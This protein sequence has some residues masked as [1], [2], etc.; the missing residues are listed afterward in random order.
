MSTP[1]TQTNTL[2]QL[3]WGIILGTLLT[4]GTIAYTL[5]KIKTTTSFGF[6]FDDSWIHAVFVRNIVEHGTF[7]FSVTE[8]SA[9]TTSIL[10]V[11]LWATLY[12]ITGKIVG[13]SYLL[14][15]GSFLGCVL[16]LA[17]FLQTVGREIPSPVHPLQK[18]TPQ[19]L[20]IIFFTLCGTT[21]FHAVSGLETLLFLALGLWGLVLLVREKHWLAGLCIGLTTLTR[22]E[23]IVLTLVAIIW[24][25]FHTTSKTTLLQ[26]SKQGIQRLLPLLIPIVTCLAA[27]LITF[28][29]TAGQWLPSTFA[30]RQWLHFGNNQDW[31]F[32]K[33]ILAYL[34]TWWEFFQQ[35][36][37][38]I[39]ELLPWFTWL[40]IGATIGMIIGG[41]VLTTLLCN[42][43]LQHKRLSALAPLIFWW[44]GHNSLYM[45]VL[46]TI[47]NVG[48]YQ[49]INI[50]VFWILLA[51][52]ATWLL[53]WRWGQGL[54]AL[55]L[56]M[57]LVISTTSITYWVD[58]AR[59]GIH[60]INTTHRAAGEYLAEHAPADS[61]VA[62]FDIGA[63][64]YFSRQNILDLGCLT[65]EEFCMYFL[66]EEKMPEY[67][68]QEQPQYLVMPESP[69]GNDFLGMY[70]KRFFQVH[71]KKTLLKAYQVDYYDDFLATNNAHVRMGIYRLYYE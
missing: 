17:L 68:Y 21:L 14:S 44:A 24:I 45:T 6:P 9:G 10:W 31:S 63:V 16:A 43:Q 56:G 35:Q 41:I 60:H 65:G 55:F 40:V 8:T 37:L 70:G 30:G 42:I 26:T 5:I 3:P 64:A 53:R 34:N 27:Q 22:I 58:I 1:T 25:L 54:V 28:Q 4:I 20:G 61:T 39:Q 11:V 59:L 29:I 57:I 32:E 19:I 66:T 33:N 38:M 71:I 50:L 7:S 18:Y 23:G 36:V 62:A 47:G 2:S 12:A 67:L 15:L 48:R 52:G 46:P 49:F 69:E 13:A 51:L